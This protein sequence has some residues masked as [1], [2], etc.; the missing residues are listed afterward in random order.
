MAERSIP[1]TKKALRERVQRLV[2]ELSSAERMER[3]ASAQARLI[4]T[5][6][7]KKARTVMVY[8]SDPSEVSS[9]DIVLA[10]LADGKRVSLPRTTRGTRTM[11]IREILD[12]R[13][14]L[15]TSRFGTFKEPLGILPTVAH[16][17]ID[18]VV[19]PGRVFDEQGRRLGRGAGYYD[20]FFA[21]EGVRA[22]AAALAFDCQIVA[23]VPVEAHDYPMD[24]IVTESRVIRVKRPRR[25]HEEIRKG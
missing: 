23:E 5:P 3:S 8:H 6:E 2:G 22:V 16:E 7:F 20:R 13:R 12:V 24:I 18:L 11:Q 15:E 4:E 14:D 10:C 25:T 21:K 19:V 9:H 17:Q 1:A